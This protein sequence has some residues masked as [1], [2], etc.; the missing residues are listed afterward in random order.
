MCIF[1][2]SFQPAWYIGQTCLSST[3]YSAW[4]NRSSH[5]Y[6]CHL[7]IYILVGISPQILDGFWSWFRNTPVK[8]TQ[9]VDSGVFG[10]LSQELKNLWFVVTDNYIQSAIV[11]DEVVY[12][13]LTSFTLIPVNKLS[14]VSSSPL[15]YILYCNTAVS[16]HVLLYL[17]M[18][19][20]WSLEA[21]WI[22]L[23]FSQGIRW[24]WCVLHQL[25]DL[26]V[27]KVF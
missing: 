21:L 1:I 24:T 17:N 11:V 13:R 20:H 18:T 7:L 12:I 5:T 10:L 15:M 2:A 27:A 3:V 26:A 25:T 22:T 19:Y 6:A 8:E 16:A 9:F 4:L 23:Q 14:H